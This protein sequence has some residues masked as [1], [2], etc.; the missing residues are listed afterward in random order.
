MVSWVGRRVDTFL[1]LAFPS[2]ELKRHGGDAEDTEGW[3]HVL[4]AEEHE[5]RV[6]AACPRGEPLAKHR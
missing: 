5:D 3:K 2:L 1:R 4:L 6:Q